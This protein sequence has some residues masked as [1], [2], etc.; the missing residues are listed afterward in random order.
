M[1]EIEF[2]LKTHTWNVACAETTTMIKR[3]VSTYLK[4]SSRNLLHYCFLALTFTTRVPWYYPDSL[5]IS[6]W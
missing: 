5:C 3:D 6:V 2:Y 4:I 1:S